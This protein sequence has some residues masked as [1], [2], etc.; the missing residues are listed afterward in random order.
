MNDALMIEAEAQFDAAADEA[1]TRRDQGKAARA[2]E[3][4]GAAWQLYLGSKPTSTTEARQRLQRVLLEGC[5]REGDMPGD[6]APLRPT[7]VDLV[8][9]LAGQAP[10][11]NAAARIRNALAA[12]E[13]WAPASDCTQILRGIAA[14]LQRPRLIAI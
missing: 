1:F 9:D 10:V 11:A 4:Y 8:T 12:A 5:G 7:I 3:R 14:W 2:N 13:V 6:L